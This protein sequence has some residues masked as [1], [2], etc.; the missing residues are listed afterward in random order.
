MLRECDR[1]TVERLSK[2]FLALI[3]DFQRGMT[4]QNLE[5]LNALAIAAATVLASTDGEHGKQAR[6]WF[7]LA[8]DNQIADFRAQFGGRNDTRRR[9]EV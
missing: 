5:L 1:E 3:H 2:R 9:S 6:D 8:L 4:G 7:L